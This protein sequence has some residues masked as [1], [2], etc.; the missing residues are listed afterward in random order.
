VN[1]RDVDDLVGGGGLGLA[2]GHAV[3]N[4]A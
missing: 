1:P 2:G 3:G 4:R